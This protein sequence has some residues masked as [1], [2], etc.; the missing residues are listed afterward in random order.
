MSDRDADIAPQSVSGDSDRLRPPR[1]PRYNFPLAFCVGILLASLAGLIATHWRDRWLVRTPPSPLGLL[2][3]TTNNQGQTSDR[4]KN[5]VLIFNPQSERLDF[6]TY[7]AVA[8]NIDDPTAGGGFQKKYVPKR[9]H[10]IFQDKNARLQGKKPIAAINGDYI[11]INNKPQGLNVSRG[12]EYSGIFNNQRSSFAISGGEA[13]SRV[14]TIQI[15]K[16]KP[17]ALNFNAVGGNGRFYKNGQFRDICED[18][19]DFACKQETNRS[20]AAITAQGYVIFLVNNSEPG[21]ELY[22]DRFD[23]V[24]ERITRDYKLGRVQEGMLFDGGLSTA[25]YFNDRIYAE[26]SNPIGSAFLIYAID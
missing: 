13:K 22:P 18:L 9:F 5:Y 10:E 7:V 3:I 12:I 20:I 23:D 19:G 21:Q 6:K 17:D 26:N 14:A 11:D 4:G 25:F 16:R 15:G 2:F 8:H 24:L 1:L